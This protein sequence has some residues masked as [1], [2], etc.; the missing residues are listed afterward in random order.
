MGA[1]LILRF[2]FAA[3]GALL[4]V[5]APAVTLPELQRE[6]QPQSL[7]EKVQAWEL[8]NLIARAETEGWNLV[9]APNWAYADEWAT[10][11][12]VLR[13]P[14]VELLLRTGGE[15]WAA[16]LEQ[17]VRPIGSVVWVGSAELGKGTL[18]CQGWVSQPERD[19]M[20]A[21]DRAV[22][23]VGKALLA[24]LGEEQ[25]DLLLHNHSP[26]DALELYEF[27]P[28]GSENWPAEAVRYV[29]LGGY[30]PGDK[31]S[32][33]QRRLCGLAV[34]IDNLTF[35]PAWLASARF[36]Y[37]GGHREA[38]AWWKGHYGSG[39]GTDVH[40]LVESGPVEPDPSLR[41]AYPRTARAYIP[42]DLPKDR[43]EGRA[44]LDLVQWARAHLGPAA[45]PLRVELLPAQFRHITD[46]PTKDITE[47][48]T[49]EEAE[50][51]IE[52]PSDVIYTQRAI[53][54]A[55][56]TRGITVTGATRSTVL[57][58]PA[59]PKGEPER[60]TLCQLLND[61]LRQCS[62]N[63]YFVRE[64]N[65][66]RLVE[67]WE[68][69]GRYCLN[70][71]PF[72]SP[73]WLDRPVTLALKKRTI[74]DLLG[75]IREQTG[76]PL[77]AGSGAEA[78]QA[79]VTALVKDVPA[80]EIV[81]HLAEYLS[82]GWERLADGRLALVPRGYLYAT[83]H[84]FPLRMRTPEEIQTR[85]QEMA[86]MT[87]ALLMEAL[88]EAHLRAAH[89]PGLTCSDLTGQARELA[90]AAAQ[91]A[92]GM[93]NP[94]EG[95]IAFKILGQEQDGSCQIRLWAGSAY[96]DLTTLSVPTIPPSPLPG[97]R[98]AQPPSSQQ[99]RV[100]DVTGVR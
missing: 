78:C 35:Q 7:P 85:S 24:S 52:V 69:T 81:E 45:E 89:D 51:Y 79:P 70:P 34:C 62:R 3:A 93:S 15:D 53:G 100:I 12:S 84:G 30:L 63:G 48:L 44:L 40:V 33:F 27:L 26:V 92:F 86:R 58:I 22:T 74:A 90:V 46:G 94:D 31:M 28:M 8:D 17:A 32:D 95:A 82:G 59:G 29:E 68:L 55:F 77:Y 61:I 76:L 23:S 9:L 54:A 98:W 21:A 91:L 97:W 37:L 43:F 4:V 20:Q 71:V 18:G 5:A 65:A 75:A 96:K 57:P 56:A 64:G 25:I 38:K 73:E 88:S 13:M 19:I 6:V 66:F 2:L 49:P 14:R 39:W 87:L 10:P 11:N 42:V 60:Y 72:L 47:L 80:R 16:S 1:R 50:I 67:E 36:V 41:Y 83:D 99:R